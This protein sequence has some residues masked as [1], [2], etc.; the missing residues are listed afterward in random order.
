MH[1][2]YFFKRQ[3]PSGEPQNKIINV[4]KKSMKEILRKV[5]KHFVLKL[6]LKFTLKLHKN[7][8]RHVA[9]KKKLQYKYTI[10]FSSSKNYLKGY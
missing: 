9:M 6:V 4:C 2:L 1:S 7:E 3:V 8:K 10:F 5:Q